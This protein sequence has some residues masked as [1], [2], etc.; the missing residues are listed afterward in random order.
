[1]QLNEIFEKYSLKT[2]SQKTKISEANIEYLLANDFDKLKKIKALGFISILER[3]YKTDFEELKMQAL[4]YY[5][6][7]PEDHRINIESPMNIEKKGSSKI[8]IFFLIVIF[9]VAFWYFN[10]QKNEISFKNYIPDINKKISDTF[11]FIKGELESKEINIQEEKIE[12][13]SVVVNIPDVQ[14]IIAIKKNVPKM[15]V[16]IEEERVKEDP[17]N[18]LKNSNIVNESM[19]ENTYVEDVNIVVK[20]EEVMVKKSNIFINPKDRLWF[21]LT[22]MQTKNRKHF[23]ISNSYELDIESKDWLVETSSAS[24]SLVQGDEIKSFNDA[25]EHYFKITKDVIE[26]LT[27]NEYIAYGGPRRW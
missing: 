22:N 9:G 2:I 12:P 17:I 6:Q 21:G 20:K 16:K 4:E 19:N 3:E 25:K 23:S 15:A 11:S 24:F 1:M 5:N 7:Q 8:L 10:M 14:E 27:R 13:K 18:I 26:T